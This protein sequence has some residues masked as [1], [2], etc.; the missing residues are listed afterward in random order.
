MSVGYYHPCLIS[1]KK[2]LKK[3]MI[4]ILIIIII[5]KICLFSSSKK[6]H[7]NQIFFT[8]FNRNLKQYVHMESIS[9][10]ASF[11]WYK[12]DNKHQ[13]FIHLLFT[14]LCILVLVVCVSVVCVWPSVGWWL[15][16]SP[17]WCVWCDEP[18]ASSP[19]PSLPE[20]T[21]FYFSFQREL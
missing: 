5:S 1:V 2:T 16:D 17:E 7:L 19:P 18:T 9:K 21:T 8:V 10:M 13:T 4:I 15:D 3:Q 12:Q 11:A 6:K 20:I 14:L